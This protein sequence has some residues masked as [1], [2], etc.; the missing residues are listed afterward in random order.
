MRLRGQVQ[1]GWSAGGGGRKRVAAPSMSTAEPC[2]LGLNARVRSAFH[3]LVSGGVS[4]VRCAPKRRG[5]T[6]TTALCSTMG[7]PGG[8]AMLRR[9]VGTGGV[10]GLSPS[11]GGLLAD[12]PAHGYGRAHN[13]PACQTPP[14]PPGA[15]TGGHG[16]LTPG[17]DRVEPSNRGIRTWNPLSGG[18][19]RADVWGRTPPPIGNRRE[20]RIGAR[21]VVRLTECPTVVHLW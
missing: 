17:A 7:P 9:T 14:P 8:S 15:T 18:G 13:P 4:S 5:R 21:A 16:G 10:R 19:G 3:S 1:S 6:A 2:P 12:T 11:F 20:Q